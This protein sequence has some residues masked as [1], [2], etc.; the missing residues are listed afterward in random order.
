MQLSKLGSPHTTALLKNTGSPAGGD[1]AE[2]PRGRPEEE[3]DHHPLPGNAE[4]D[5]GPDRGAQQP[6]HQAVPGEQRPG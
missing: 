6:Q 4:R 3:G 2:M 1:P 5:P